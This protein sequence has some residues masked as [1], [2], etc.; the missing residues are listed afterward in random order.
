MEDALRVALNQAK[1][2]A[3]HGTYREVVFCHILVPVLLEWIDDQPMPVEQSDRLPTVL[4]VLAAMANMPPRR[5]Y[6]LLHGEDITI[7][8]DKADRLMMAIGSHISRVEGGIVTTLEAS[9]YASW[10][11][12]QMR[13]WWE[14][15]GRKWPQ[16]GKEWRRQMTHIRRAYH[17]ACTP[18]R[19][20]TDAYA[21]SW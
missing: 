19:R 8:L 20:T 17:E 12:D 2:R 18:H 10:Q 4:G 7:D 9:V 13:V 6:G 5:L 14:G 15:N 11:R 16:P 3:K 1:E 21:E